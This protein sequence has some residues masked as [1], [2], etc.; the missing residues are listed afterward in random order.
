MDYRHMLNIDY[1]P[2]F[3]EYLKSEFSGCEI[4]EMSVTSRSASYG[5]DMVMMLDDIDW[6]S[7]EKMDLCNFDE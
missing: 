6:K 7:C 2:K 5:M 1:M 4:V 3:S